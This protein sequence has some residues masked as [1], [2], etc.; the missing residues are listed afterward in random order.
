MKKILCPLGILCLFLYMLLYPSNAFQGSKSGLMLWFYKVLP[1]LLP[2]MILSNFLM[3]FSALDRLLQPLE[4]LSR[5]LF[6]LSPWGLYALSLG[7]FCG[8]PMGGKITGDL[9][10]RGKITY[11]EA[12]YLLTFVNNVS[13]GF[14]VNYVIYQCLDAPEYT[15]V[16]FFILYSS[17]FL[18]AVFFRLILKPDGRGPHIQKKETS[19]ASSLGERIDVSIMNS[20]E[21]ITKLGGYMILASILAS[22]IMILP[23][24]LREVKLFLVSITEITTGIQVISD[25]VESF[26]IRYLDTLCLTSLGGLSILLQTAGMIRPAGLS[27]KYYLAGKIIQSLFTAILVLVI[28]QII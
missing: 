16:T 25:T 19:R 4:P 7:L 26:L 6:A 18:T 1:T 17:L 9:Y 28:T 12:C 13:P 3:S 20:F 23:I 5:Y 24:P 8:Y 10:I 2:F 27:L 21:T 14:L 22:A 11:K 15:A